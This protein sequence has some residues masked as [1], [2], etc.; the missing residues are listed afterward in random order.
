MIIFFFTISYIIINFKQLS[1]NNAK[2][3]AS[4]V[5]QKSAKMIEKSLSKDLTELKTLSKSFSTFENMYKEENKSLYINMYKEVYK[6]NKNF[7]KIWDTWEVQYFD[8]SWHNEF[9]RYSLAVYRD[10][11]NTIETSF[12][13]R[14]TAS[15]MDFYLN[16]KNIGKDMMWEPYWE[17][18]VKDGETILRFMT[19]L[20]TP[21]LKDNTVVGLVAADVLTDRFKTIIDKIKPYKSTL[22]YLVS[23][24]GF[25]V[26]HPDSKFIGKDLS[27]VFPEYENQFNL[28]N[29]IEKGNIK[30]FQGIDKN[31]EDVLLEVVPVNVG[32]YNKPW[33]LIIVIPVKV[34][35]SE[36]IT[37]QRIAILVSS[38]GLIILIIVILL[39]AK[40]ISEP[41]V[42]ITNVL[43]KLSKGDTRNINDIH[44]NSRDE[45]EDMANSVNTLKVGLVSTSEFAKQIGEGNLSADFTPLSDNDILGNSL[46]S[47][48][49]SL[50]K[51]KIAEEKRKLEEEKQN[52]AT[53]G[54]AMFGEI[55]RTNSNNIELLSFEIM[56]NLV[57]YLEVNQ[58]AL[59]II[60]EDN[61][62]ELYLDMKS[63]IAYGRDK[64][65]TKKIK[66]GDNLVG[67]CAFEKKTIYITDIP[68]DYIEITSGM[69]TANPNI[70]LLVP[71]ILNDEIF[72]VIEVA[73]FNKIDNYKIEFVEKIGESVASTISAV[74]I[75]DRTSFLL[76]QS[77]SQAENLATQEEEMRQ[78]IEELQATQEEAARHEYEM[79]NIINTL[80]ETVFTVEYN[81]DGEIIDCNDRYIN[82]LGVSK[83]EI[84]GQHHKSEVNFNKDTDYYNNFWN[85]LRHG[86]SRKENSNK[87]YNNKE[88]WFDE[89]YTPIKSQNEDTP[90]KILKI[91]LD[92]TEQKNN[93]LKLKDIETKIKEDKKIIT[94]YESIVDKLKKELEQAKTKSNK[95]QQQTPIKNINKIEINIQ[96]TGNNLIDWVTDFILEIDEFDKQHK[97][98]IE[99]TNSLYISFKKGKTKKEIKDNLK[100]LI[101]FA[102]YN[103]GK[104]EQ[105]FEQF[106]FELAE[107]HIQEH[108]AFI[109]KLKQFQKDYNSNKVKF[110][111]DIMT[112]IKEWLYNHFTNSD[113]KYKELFKSKLDI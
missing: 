54:M 66:I 43:K 34:I 76:E 37:M 81:L 85:D 3:L 59:F 74:K 101:D 19:T 51:A 56:S 49:K 4:N 110:L 89:T 46:L 96:A 70:L 33:S 77:K 98:I 79:T 22:A 106:K 36:A 111:D 23:N 50:Q 90:Y 20:S 69:G 109:K 31:N 45:I 97:Q 93:E 30:T 80:E 78:N 10:E 58:G 86:I 9:G 73:S 60:E 40:N 18:T 25:F 95:S 15:F 105:Y 11:S 57:N 1:I 38:I 48:R 99:L 68:Q 67:R 21:I 62:N 94:K 28:K 84:L 107:Q 112:Y 14:D 24:S 87:T 75:N 83:D 12:D 16:L 108:Q 32:Q 102:S 71:L 72:G 26:T 17:G 27:V 91:S 53:K 63:A 52:W 7:F 41:L 113:I 103:F 35:L 65:I 104:E 39:I 8:T 92:I 47:M 88:Y 29:I 42:K 2:S 61:N 100:N 13:L 64:F 82:L 6:K 5:V 44:H 55:L